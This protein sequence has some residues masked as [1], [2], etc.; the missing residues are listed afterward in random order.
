MMFHKLYFI[1]CDIDLISFNTI[2]CELRYDTIRYATI[3]V[4]KS[5]HLVSHFIES[6]RIAS[7]CI[8]SHYIVFCRIVSYRMSHIASNWREN[9]NS[10]QACK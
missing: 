9:S 10:L 1:Y 3:D 6:C 7:H 2:R 4:Y 8:V 5:Y